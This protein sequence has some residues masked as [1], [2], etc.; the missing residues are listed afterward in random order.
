MNEITIVNVE[1]G[2]V[3]ERKITAEEVAQ[4]EAEQQQIAANQAAKAAAKAEAEAVK[5]AAEAKL[6]ALGLTKEDLQAL[7]L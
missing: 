3:I 6:E 1:T 4:L 7:G 5:A 2:E